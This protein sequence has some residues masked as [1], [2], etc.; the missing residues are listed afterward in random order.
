VPEVL[1][2]RVYAADT[3]VV[4]DVTDPLDLAGGRF[5]LQ[6]RDGTGKCTPHDGPADV[7]IGLAELATLYMGAHRAT[8]LLRADRITELR[9]GAL[10]DMDAAFATE[11]APYCGTLF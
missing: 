4:L 8:H 5:L 1:G 3:D 7:E 11:R 6:T 9:P 10:R 2:A